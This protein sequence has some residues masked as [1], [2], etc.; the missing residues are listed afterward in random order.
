MAGT[1][2]KEERLSRRSDIARLLS[3]GRY[4]DAGCVRYCFA[5]GGGKPFSRVLLSVRKRD[6]KRAV[7][8]NLIRRR[9]RESYRLQKDILE[10][11]PADVMLV[12]TSKEIL[13]YTEIFSSV[14]SAL[15][16]IRKRLKKSHGGQLKEGT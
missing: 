13:P 16:A 11:F 7:W 3:E 9:L 1:L 6:F 8:R 2:S 15:S 5:G 4:G 12:Y 10:G 14:G